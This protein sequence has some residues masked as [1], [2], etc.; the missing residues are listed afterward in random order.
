[1]AMNPRLMR[2]LARR[3]AASATHLE[4]LDWASRVTTNGG[5]VSTETLAAVST[6]C[7]AI[8]AAGIRDRFYRLN[9]FCGTGLS[10]ALVPLYRGPSRTGTQYGGSTDTNINFVNGNY[11]ETGATSGLTGNGANKYLNTGYPANTLPA[12]NTHLGVGLL[13]NDLSSLD[14]RTLLG[15]WNDAAN[16]VELRERDR[17]GAVS[18]AATLTRYQTIGDCF[19]DDITEFSLAVGNIVAA[20]PTMYRNGVASGA[21]ATSSQNFPNATNLFVFALNTNSYGALNSTAS[22][23]GWYSVGATMTASQALSYHNALVA[24]NTTLSRT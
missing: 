19:G 24:F 18:R 15:A 4:A 9:L 17:T 3:Q 5:S 6:F 14:D 7:S 13:G 10:A 12:N 23:V 20:W 2:P 11:L 21:V 16:I 22:R 8:D 1:M